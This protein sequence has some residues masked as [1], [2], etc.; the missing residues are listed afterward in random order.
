VIV[1]HRGEEPAQVSSLAGYVMVCRYDF[2]VAFMIVGR[3]RR[4]SP[5]MTR[6]NCGRRR[7]APDSG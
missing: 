5:H 1:G 6:D 2:P 7:E 3:T 4:Y